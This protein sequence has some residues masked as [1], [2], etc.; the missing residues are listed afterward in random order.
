MEYD[1]ISRKCAIVRLMKPKHICAIL[2]VSFVVV[3]SASAAET[4]ATALLVLDKSDN[5]LVIIDA[6][7]LKPAGRVPVGDDPHEIVVS[8]DGPGLTREQRARIGKRGLRLDETKP[9]SGL[10]LSIVMDLAHSYHGTCELTE[11]PKGGLAVR[12]DL[13]AA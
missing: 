8:D 1:L 7:T 4:P 5:N 9:G 11:G 10:W 2:L 3:A 13:P 6:T 12:L